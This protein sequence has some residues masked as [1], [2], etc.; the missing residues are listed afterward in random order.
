M[1]LVCGLP[2]ALLLSI[3]VSSHVLVSSRLSSS[4]QYPYP[5]IHPSIQYYPIHL[6]PPVALLRW[7]VVPSARFLSLPSLSLLTLARLFCPLS[8]ACPP[9]IFLIPRSCPCRLFSSE[10]GTS[11]DCFAFAVNSLSRHLEPNAV[12]QGPEAFLS[13]RILPAAS[14]PT[15]PSKPRSII[16]KYRIAHLRPT[17][18]SPAHHHHLPRFTTE[19]TLPFSSSY[20]L[21]T[22]PQLPVDLVRNCVAI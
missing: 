18:S 6:T 3:H 9:S 11:V 15:P 2:V 17:S 4:P 1:E 13:P 22:G 19:P 12:R 8:R 10:N 7:P 21:A 20:P 5:S 16:R 14:Q